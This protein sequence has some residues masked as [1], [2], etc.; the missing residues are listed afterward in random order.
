MFKYG[1]ILSI[2]AY[3]NR[4]VKNYFFKFRIDPIPNISH[5]YRFY[6]YYKNPSMR[7]RERA[8]YQ[9]DK[10]YIR[11]KRR[12]CYLQDPWDDILRGDYNNRK[13]WK[14]KKIKRQWMKNQ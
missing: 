8:L 11:P 9:Q 2:K 13:S 6:G 3:W 10:E 5:R 14:N 1:E 7:K 12:N 4:S